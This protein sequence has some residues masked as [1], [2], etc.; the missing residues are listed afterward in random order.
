MLSLPVSGHYG[1][2]GCQDLV[3]NPL[4]VGLTCPTNE[5]HQSKGFQGGSFKGIY[6][7]NGYQTW[8]VVS[9]FKFEPLP[10]END[11][12]WLMLLMEKSPAPVEVGS[13]SHYLQGFMHH[14][15]CR[16]S[17]INSICQMDWLNHQ[18]VAP[19]KNVFFTDTELRTRR[20]WVTASL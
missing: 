20:R 14:G 2:F 19:A 15:W 13:L 8:V 11:P 12:V 1:Q 18:V 4:G 7:S 3:P 6:G 9:Y 10:G 17:S 5:S 16:I